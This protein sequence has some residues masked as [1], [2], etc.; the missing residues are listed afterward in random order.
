MYTSKEDLLSVR[1][2]RAPASAPRRQQRWLCLFL[3]LYVYIHILV[4]TRA[5]P[6][7]SD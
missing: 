5:E 1:P 4:D 2:I 7:N 6:G 3:I